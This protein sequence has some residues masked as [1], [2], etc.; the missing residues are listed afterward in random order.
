MFFNGIYRVILRQGALALM[1]GLSSLEAAQAGDRLWC[2]NPIS[3]FTD[4]A[5]RLVICPLELQA[6]N[7]GAL[8]RTIWSHHF[9]EGTADLHPSGI[10]QLNRLARQYAYSPCLQIFLQTAHDLPYKGDP[11][12][13]IAA[14][15]ALDTKRL[16]VI[17]NYLTYVSRRQDFTLAIHD[18]RP[19]GLS[20]AEAKR[21][22]AAMQATALG[23]LP[24]EVT[25]SGGL[26]GLLSGGGGGG[27]LG[28]GAMPGSM[29]T[30]LGG[31][32]PSL[33][34]GGGLLDGQNGE[35]SGSGP[36]GP[37]SGASPSGQ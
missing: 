22:V 37:P 32:E 18:P 34:T 3:E 15:N 8:D 14:Q 27:S 17:A 10:S 11:K 36:L 23:G 1:C 30:M 2:N 4:P 16:G 24:A 25:V 9:I 5:R 19:V 12:A 35:S 6:A 33:P 7:G 21:S 13:Y 28:G 29:P 26:S 31:S 20:A